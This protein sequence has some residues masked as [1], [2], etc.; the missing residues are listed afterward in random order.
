[1]SEQNTDK[2]KAN[3]AKNQKA[4][5][6]VKELRK[7]NPN[8]SPCQL[9][10]IVEKQFVQRFS[11]VGGGRAVL[12]HGVRLVAQKVGKSQRN[13][14]SAANQGADKFV[15][16]GVETFL[17]RYILS[18]ALLYGKNPRNASQAFEDILGEDIYVALKEAEK[19][20]TTT[21]QNFDV[22]ATGLIFLGMIPQLKKHSQ[23]LSA[24]VALAGLGTD[25]F[26][27]QG[28][29]KEFAEK[30]IERVR[31][32]LGT[33]PKEFSDLLFVDF[34]ASEDDQEKPDSSARDK[35]K[36][37]KEKTVDATH[38]VRL[39]RT[40]NDSATKEAKETKKRQR[41]E[42]RNQRKAQKALDQAKKAQAKADEKR[43]KAED[44]RN[45][46]I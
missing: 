41:I 29:Q 35:V 14:K 1:M 8:A 3:T 21:N 30:L 18:T 37:I 2:N 32:K 9:L 11:V 39:I 15:E 10:E 45:Q 4:V 38:N 26:K 5:D 7:K 22:V 46:N 13:F 44:L 42:D 25:F 27:Q 6:R 34:E 24:M 12:Q 36:K 20:S 16:T 19:N 31:E 23:A 40:P 17:K 28:A 33:P 43:Q